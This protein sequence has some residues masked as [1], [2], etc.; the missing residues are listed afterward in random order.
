VKLPATASRR[1]A[2]TAPIPGYVPLKGVAAL[3]TGTLVDARKGRVALDSTVDGR[4]IGDGG[5]RQRAVLAAGI[6][7][8]R[9]QRA[10]LGS[11][12]RVPT[13]FV[14]TSAPGA[15]SAC[16][17]T[18]SSG[19]IKGRGRSIVRTLTASTQKG[20]F[21][22]VGAAGTSTARDATWVTQ[23]RCDGTRTDVGR[24]RVAVAAAAASSAKATTVT[25]GR[26]Y[27]I[28]AKL[29]AAKRARG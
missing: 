22:I 12:A 15:E 25:A 1:L 29:F 24:G 7:R 13:D 9:Q 23:D 2:Q 20:L 18:P 5:G 26:S 10:A 17:R 3:P 11:T 8:I 16:V 4:R 14:L 19:P 21:R 6:F 28:K 27:T